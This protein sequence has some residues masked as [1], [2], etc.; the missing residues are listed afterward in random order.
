MA[1]EAVK[2]A[3]KRV[4][5]KDQDVKYVAGDFVIVPIGVTGGGRT[6]AWGMLYRGKQVTTEL[7]GHAHARVFDRVRDAKKYGDRMRGWIGRWV[8][9]SKNHGHVYAYYNDSECHGCA[10][11]RATDPDFAK[12]LQRH[13]K[14]EL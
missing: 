5:E 6:Y 10:V 11:L 8:E 1:T 13:I 2:N 14:H 9:E 4:T 7:R 12:W 3:W